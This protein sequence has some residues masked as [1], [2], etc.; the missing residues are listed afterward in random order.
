MLSTIAASM[1]V[2]PL[3]A[4]DLTPSDRRTDQCLRL[5]GSTERL[6]LP[7]VE[8]STMADVDEDEP[9]ACGTVPSY[10]PDEPQKARG[11]QAPR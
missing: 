1:L 6:D 5:Y 9:F 7:A 4:P 11:D 8:I 10:Y 3:L 2:L